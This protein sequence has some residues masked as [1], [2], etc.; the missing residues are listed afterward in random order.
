MKQ[1]TTK[2]S[3][4]ISTGWN[5]AGIFITTFMAGIFSRSAASFFSYVLQ[6]DYLLFFYIEYA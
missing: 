3:G 2:M 5:N 1:A 6:I 4:K